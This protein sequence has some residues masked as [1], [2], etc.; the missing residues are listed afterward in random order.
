MVTISEVSAA[1]HAAAL[2]A[3]QFERIGIL[4]LR[5]EAGAAGD[6]VAQLHPAELFAGV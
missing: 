2:A 6:A 4:L 3:N 5:H 1:H